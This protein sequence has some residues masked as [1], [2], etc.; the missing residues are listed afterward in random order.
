MLSL[1]FMSIL[2]PDEFQVC[3]ELSFVKIWNLISLILPLL[4]LSVGLS[5]ACK[6]K[7]FLKEKGVIEIIFLVQT[8]Q[9]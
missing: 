7:I 9:L 4:L 1:F 2:Y 3:I 8:S 6:G 5:A